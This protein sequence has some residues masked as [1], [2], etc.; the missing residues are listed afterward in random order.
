MKTTIK[1]LLIVV[2]IINCYLLFG[3]EYH[4]MLGDSNKWYVVK[5]F[6]GS[7]TDLYVSKDDTLLNGKHYKFFLKYSGAIQS[8][9]PDTVGFFRE[10]SLTMKLWRWWD[11]TEVVYLDFSLNKNDS[12][13]LNSYK[14]F[15]GWYHVDSVGVTNILAGNRKTIFLSRDTLGYIEKPIWI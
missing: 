2:F 3:Q 7:Q 9:K 1:Y 14:Y 11:T 13:F 4:T 12:I 10:D 15:T 5:T 8:L 6:E